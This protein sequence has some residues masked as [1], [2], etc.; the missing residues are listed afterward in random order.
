[1]VN[2]AEHRIWRVPEMIEG[3][4]YQLPTKDLL[5]A[6]S[7]CKTW[8]DA[9]ERSTK[10]QKRLFLIA[11][12]EVW[13]DLEAMK[14]AG[15]RPKFNP[16][17]QKHLRDLEDGFYRYTKH[18]KVVIR[19]TSRGCHR[20]WRR[21]LLVQPPVASFSTSVDFYKD[22]PEYDDGLI[23]E[24]DVE[25]ENAKGLMMGHLTRAFGDEIDRARN[26]YGEFEACTIKVGAFIARM[27]NIGEGGDE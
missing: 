6:K 14:E 26:R 4:L 3:I 22:E 9:I 24:A 7:V 18:G 2:Q 17:L 20:V 12:G 15:V 21:M 27:A 13:S 16:L 5:F 19:N 10:L 1:M 25:L 8:K 23:P 11:D